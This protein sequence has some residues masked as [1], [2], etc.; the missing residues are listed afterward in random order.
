MASIHDVARAAGVS[1]STVSYALSGKRPVAEDTRQRIAA[2]ARELGYQP[3]AGAR[4]LAG[5]RTQLLALTAPLHAETSTPAHMAFVLAVVTAARRF[6]YDVV[7]LTEEEATGG[8]SRVTST[9]LV[10]GIIVLDV[11]VDDRRVG[12]V[13]DLSIPAVL[14][15][16]PGDTA[17]LVCVD[18]D[19]EAAA[20]L[21]VDRLGDAGH[22]SIVL[23][24]DP[25]GIYERGSNFPR[26]FR[27]AFT[28]RAAERGIACTFAESSRNAVELRAVVDTVLGAA[29]RPTGLVMQCAES[30]QLAV[31]E[32]LE[33][34]DIRIPADLSVIS[35][36]STFDTSTFQP[37]LDVIPL[38]PAESCDRAVDLLMSAMDGPLDPVVELLDPTYLAHG[39]VGRPLV[40]AEPAAR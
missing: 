30:I 12:L 37:P 22:T 21:A 32:H 15:G 6:D 23:L 38:V 7:L 36:A 13:R 14:V 29:P 19:F 20:R 11:A 18:L 25:H 5:R 40:D 16:V 3:N 9:K 27:D 2:A 10:D 33:T 28:A 26:R 17:G 39:S 8:L 31:L 1:I 4:M 35:A 34:R 24:G